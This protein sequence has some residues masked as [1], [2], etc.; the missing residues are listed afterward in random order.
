[1][2]PNFYAKLVKE[3]EGLRLPHS[4]EIQYVAGE[5]PHSFLFLQSMK[6]AF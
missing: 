4:K 1:M 3:N 5:L 2:K 6:A